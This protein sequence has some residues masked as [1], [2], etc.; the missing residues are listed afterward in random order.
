MPCTFSTGRSGFGNRLVRVLGRTGRHISLPSCQ[1]V[2]SSVGFRRRVYL[3]TDTSSLPILPVS[4]HTL[5]HT[6]SQKSTLTHT[7]TQT[8][9]TTHEHY[10]RTHTSFHTHSHNTSHLTPHPTPPHTPATYIYDK[11]SK[12]KATNHGIDQRG[13]VW[14]HHSATHVQEYR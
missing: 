9:N 6:P 2:T 3:V 7:H 12:I 8:K 13:P 10:T 1:K 4:T 5:T 11:F 14:G